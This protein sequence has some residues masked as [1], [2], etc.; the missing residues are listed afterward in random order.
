MRRVEMKSVVMIAY[1]FPPEG[2][3]GAFRPL[4]FIR[5]LPSLGWEPTIITL[6]AD[7]HE[8]YDPSLLSLVPDGIEVIR[9]RNRDP[10]QAF[11]AKREIR[12][13]QRVSK[14]SADTV[15]RIQSAHNM[16]VRSS[17][18]EVVRTLEACCYHPDITMGWIRPAVKATLKICARKRPDAV[19]ATAGPVSSF[20][21]AQRASQRTG[22]P[23]VLD[24]RDAWT[25]T[26]SG[27]EARRPRWARR[28]DQRT[29]FHLL[30]GAQAVIFRYDTEAE[31]FWRAY[32][33]ALEASR[34]YII[35]N[36]YEGAVN[37]FISPDGDRCKVL[38]TGTLSDYRY[39]TLLQALQFLKQSEPDLA[40]RLHFQFVGEGT[41]VLG[42]EAAALGLADLVTTSGPI[43]HADVIR[44]SQ[45]AH[46]LLV[47][48][49]PPTMTGY[50]LFAAAKLFG[51][52][53]AGRPIVGV[54]PQDE[55]KKLLL[56]VG[57]ST[58]AN[59]D[60][61][62]EIVA[63]FRK[64]LHA[65]AEG[66][67]ASVIPSPLACQAYSTER[68]TRALVCALEGKPASDAFV[69]GQ[70]EIPASLQREISNRGRKSIQRESF[71]SKKDVTLRS[72]V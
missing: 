7:F 39:D 44:L 23:Y 50:E 63:L 55:A 34:I 46:A 12:M 2:N 42:N 59:V 62:P 19:W 58:V 40:K 6:D 41:G 43:S 14:A 45:Q 32:P 72:R 49:R 38:Y 22:V 3:A 27:F 48:G 5:Q 4:R 35:P 1:D 29:M 36:G 20:L 31:C 51:Y 66:R 24:F 13:R 52:L 30:K 16:P 64:L 11:Q 71:L 9:V 18:R 70:A 21:V 26:V 17:I 61:V 53:K 65:W 68:Q 33:G 25:I 56:C 60:S 8:R 28:S 57:V 67:L 15:A 47:L 54:L 69:P 10:W 37:E